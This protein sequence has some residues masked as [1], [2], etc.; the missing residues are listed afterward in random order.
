[1]NPMCSKDF[2]KTDHHSQYPAKT[3]QVYSNFTPRSSRLANVLREYYDEKIVWFG[4]QYFIEEFLIKE[5]NENF[6]LKPIEEA[7]RYYKRRLNT[8]LGEGAVDISNIERLH[9]LGHLPL[10][11]KSLPEGSRVN[12]GVPPLTITNTHDDFGWLPNS[13]ETVL[14]TEL[15]GMSTSATIA[16]EY[17]RI[18]SKYAEDTGAPL[19]FVPLQG[20][21]FSMRGMFGRHAAAMSGAGHLTSFVGT[22]SIPAID[23]LEEWYGADAEKE[24]IGC[25]VPA[26]E[27]AVMCLGEQGG[28]FETF[29]T[30][31]TEKY[32]T[33][34][35]SIVSD[36]WDYWK[37]ITEYLPAL[38]KDILARKPNAIGLNKVVIRPDSGDPVDI[39]CGDEF[40]VL[41]NPCLDFGDW[42]IWVAEE[43][44]ESFRNNLIADTPHCSEECLW[45]NDADDY[46][47]VTYTPDLNRHDKTFYYIDN[48]GS[49]LSKCE[50]VQIDLT[51]E[52]KGSIQC[53]WDTFGGTV[54]AA[55]FKELDHHIGLIYGDSITLDRANVILSRL[56]DKGFASSNIVFGIG[57]YTYQYNTRDS[58]GWAMKAT[59]GR[60]DGKGIEIYK[61]PKTDN[62]TK[63]SAKGLLRVEKVGD[64]YILHD[65]QTVEQEEQGVLQ[66]VYLDGHI[67][68]N[69]TTL[70]E[71][72]SRLWG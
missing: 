59:Y 47:K 54:N 11:I 25:S 38:K 43:M 55:G 63:K 42:K 61:D 35:I 41:E 37:V 8:S 6:F 48:Y 3:E 18:L 49:T 7:V 19:D 51:P 36:T 15:W 31:I 53:L 1:M 68:A 69:R 30:L 5:F 28:E 27:H 14:S 32:P 62:G 4:L 56:K 10:H 71:I 21:D 52:Q 57:S 22:D 2:Y 58:F 70:Q 17:R 65:Q 13:L 72:R 12:I 34:I 45:K 60:V 66:T 24:L 44:D 33:G 40:R 16:Y 64:D 46:Y 20:H 26:T 50:F 67:D 39:V 29:K 23:F 9:K